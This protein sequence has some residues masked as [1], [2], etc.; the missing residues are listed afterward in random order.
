MLVLSRPLAETPVPRRVRGGDATGTR[1]RDNYSFRGAS[2]ATA[3]CQ[4]MQ[5]PREDGMEG[6]GAGV[7]E[8]KSIH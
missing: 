1:L 2:L 6:G 5:L 3:G 7:R 8:R 4:G